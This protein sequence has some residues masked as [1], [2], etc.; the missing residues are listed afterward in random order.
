[1]ATVSF[2]L[3]SKKTNPSAIMLKMYYNGKEFA[4]ASGY[5]VNPRNWNQK[6]QR[7]TGKDSEDINSQLQELSSK[8]LNAYDKIKHLEVDNDMIRN[9][10]SGNEPTGV[11]N[12]SVTLYSYIED[13]MERKKGENTHASKSRLSRY[14]NTYKRLKQFGSEYYKRELT[15]KDI[16]I[17]FRDK[18]VNFLSKDVK[19]ADSTVQSEVKTFKRFMNLAY[20][21]KITDN[22][23]FKSREF[24]AP[25][26]K[27]KPVYLSDSEIDRLYYYKFEGSEDKEYDLI[28]DIFIIGCRTGLRVSDYWRCTGDTVENGI[29][30]IDDTQKTGEPVYIP[31]HWQVKNILDKYDNDIPAVTSIIL[32]KNIKKICKI[33]GFDNLVTDM[34]PHHSGFCPKYELIT[35]HT[36]RRSCATNLYLAGFDLYFIQGILG[37]RK[38]DTTIGYLGI[39]RKATAI[40][41]A[42]NP[43]FTGDTVSD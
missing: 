27:K 20:I 7:V 39:T 3:R 42:N 28:R 32:N 4:M 24:K 38:I 17:P 9:T 41:Y 31:M 19:L 33:L 8:L 11:N 30:C 40:R 14:R 36:A 35:T 18:Y 23:L 37:H 34:R 12:K 2:Y 13:V 10:V 26:Y 25:S 6:R 29:I 5:S 22:I 15:F 21:E 43:Y 16:D 1:M